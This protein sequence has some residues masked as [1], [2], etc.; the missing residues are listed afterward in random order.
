MN[1]SPGDSLPGKSGGTPANRPALPALRTPPALPER[2][3]ASTPDRLL[4]ALPAPRP[5][6]GALVLASAA[7][8]EG[9]SP[10][11]RTGEVV[12]GTFLVTLG[13]PEGSE[14]RPC[15]ADRLPDPRPVTRAGGARRT[16]SG[17]AAP[18]GPVAL[19]TGPGGTALLEREAEVER[20]R[21]LLSQGRSIR[22]AGPSGSGRSALL[23]AVADS[24][25]GL[26]PDGVVRLTGYRRTLADLLQDLFTATH[27]ASGYRPQPDRL[28]QLLAGVGAIV[29]VDDVEFG[30]AALEE[31]LDS[32]PECAFL[33][34]TTPDTAPP[35][36][37]SRLA[38]A[39]L[40]GLSRDAC[41]ELLTGLAGRPLDEFE[42]A[43]AV[44]LWFESEG[45]PLR[46]VQA[47]A[48]LRHR[49]VA[50]DALAVAR[51]ERASLFGISTGDDHEPDDDPAVHE[52][53]LRQSVPLP[54]VA[55]SAA[56]AVRLAEGLGGPA[57]AVLRLAVA[58]GGQCPTAPHLPALIDVG[59]GESALHELVDCGLAVS[60]GEHHRL[61][62]GVHRLL[63]QEWQTGD[64]AHGAAQHFAW[65]VGHSSVS[66]EQVA[67]E[68]EV[69]IA[70]MYADRD[71]GRHG[72]VV[73]LARAA[74]PAFAVALRWG[75]WEQTL[76]L[77]LESA[78]A[79]GAVADEAWFH[80]ELGVLALA[81]GA[82]NRA[83]TEFDAS[84]ALRGA[85]GD[86]R[87]D[88]AV[89]RM[90]GL[91]AGA[92]NA[93]AA[94][95]GPATKQ[96]PTRTMGQIP[97]R[98]S[99]AV[100]RDAR[101]ARRRNLMAAGAGVVLLAGLGTVVGLT[102]ADGDPASPAPSSTVPEVSDDVVPTDLGNVTLPPSSAAPSTSPSGTA[103]TTSPP[104]SGTAQPTPTATATVSATATATA[105][106]SQSKEGV[107]APPSLTPTPHQ[108]SKNSTARPKPSGSASKTTAPA[109][110]TPPTDPPA[111]EPTVSD[112]PT[113]EATGS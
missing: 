24:C 4:P 55:E 72:S 43:W 88:A 5:P 69:L 15:P 67:A 68:A 64:I 21:G 71:T 79:A 17:P 101:T 60:T 104:P 27:R 57:R 107:P 81:T 19:G 8:A 61:S 20:L 32:A 105:T 30:G 31:L 45:L 39:T 102:T 99:G 3:A 63:A 33:I 85:L 91:L 111:T 53:A 75:A 16:P 54:S 59:Q 82:E 47:G 44:D 49:D 11:L 9:E 80:H 50:A 40:E 7:A 37:D 108:S 74:A 84:I 35:P 87:S 14:A 94:L 58:L 46:F 103:A 77:G 23:A 36:A 90:L 98:R 34:S 86:T 10:R 62:E 97:W 38:E 1:P 28:A 13:L 112:P 22:V 100:A 83:R 18:T 78:R 92:E 2:P 66:P 93:T 51:E 25:A 26:A 96:L 73:L 56:P 41:L 52:E 113:D 6:D 106:A 76:R 29:V 65:W 110:P 42:R 109:E 48:L 89:R 70:A 95:G 12:A